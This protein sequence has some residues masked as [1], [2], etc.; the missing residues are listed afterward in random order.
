MKVRIFKWFP[1]G[2]IRSYIYYLT[3]VIAQL[4]YIKMTVFLCVWPRHWS[5]RSQ[6]RS[7][8]DSEQPNKSPWPSIFSRLLISQPGLAAS[9]EASFGHHS[10]I[11][12]SSLSSFIINSMPRPGL[13][14]LG[15]WQLAGRSAP[16]LSRAPVSPLFPPPRPP[17][18]SFQLGI[19]VPV[20]IPMP[21]HF[22]FLAQPVPVYGLW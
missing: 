19:A 7:T 3:I 4:A 20:L 16:R 6:F 13:G 8:W 11:N 5:C 21:H 22:Q 10:G 18:S 9:W 17:F 2:K 12:W 15:T 1:K 14:N